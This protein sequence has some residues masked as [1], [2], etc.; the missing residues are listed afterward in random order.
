MP[1][2]RISLLFFL[3]TIS[4]WGP[5][6][7]SQK[8]EDSKD[9]RGILREIQISDQE[10]LTEDQREMKTLK[11]ELLISKSEKKAIESLNSLLKKKRGTL[12][13]PD[14][15]YR[16]A[17]LHMRRSKSGRFFDLNQDKTTNQWKSFPVPNEKGADS[18][19]ASIEIYNKIEKNFPNYKDLDS[20]LFNNAFA[21]QQI[22]LNRVAEVL[23]KKL[24]EKFSKSPLRA[25]GLLALAELL[26]EQ[27]RFK[28]A[29]TYFEK[30]KEFPDSRVYNYGL[31]KKAWTHYNMK[32]SDQGVAV[33]LEVLRLNPPNTTDAKGYNLRKESL[34]DLAV[35]V[36]DTKGPELLYSFFK[37]IETEEE[38]GQTILELAKLY[39]GH[40]RFK[41][42]PT[43]V[44]EYNDNHKLSPF[45]VKTKLILVNAYEST[46][47]REQVLETLKSISDLCQVGSAWYKAQTP[48]IFSESCKEDFKEVSLELSKKWW[49]IWLKNKLH[50]EFS[51]LTER[52]L[53][54]ILANDDPN[55]PDVKT[56]F[57]LAELLFQQEKYK[58]SSEEYEKVSLATQDTALA[59]DASYGALYSYEKFLNS[60]KSKSDPR[61]RKLVVHYKDNFPKGDHHWP[62]LMKWA[63]ILY[64]EGN[65]DESQKTLDLIKNN[66]GRKD[67]ITQSQDLHLDI[68][69]LKKDFKSL[70][71]KA[72]EFTSTELSAERK[73]H[74]QKISSEAHFSEVQEIAKSGQ[75]LK[76]AE[77]L[78]K[79]FREHP[80]SALGTEALWQSMS[81]Y[82]SLGRL[83]EASDLTLE[84]VA[85]HPKDKRNLDALKEAANA[86]VD[87]GNFR[88]ALQVLHKIQQ[89]EPTKQEDFTLK[90]AHYL[91]L[92]GDKE[93]ARKLYSQLE[94]SSNTVADKK[95]YRDLLFHT[96]SLQEKN[97]DNYRKFKK[98]QA[99]QGVEPF[100]S[101]AL[102]S[103][104][105]VLLRSG[106]ATEAFELARKI[107]ARDTEEEV[108]AQARSIQA[109]IL[110]EEFLRQSVQSSKEDRIAIVIGLKAEKMEKA[111]SSYL[112][113]LKQTKTSELQRTALE[114]IDRIY[115]NY[116]QSMGGF[117]AP[118]SV[119]ATDAQA[120]EIEIAKTLPPIRERRDQNRKDLL[121]LQ[122]Q[123]RGPTNEWYDSSP[124]NSIEPSVQWPTELLPPVFHPLTWSKDGPWRSVILTETQQ[125]KSCKDFQ[126][127]REAE[128]S[129]QNA[130]NSTKD[131]EAFNKIL[132][133]ASACSSGPDKAQLP[134][135][136]LNLLN[137]PRTKAL[138]Y[139]YLSLVSESKGLWDKAL[140][141]IEKAKLEIENTK[142]PSYLN[143]PQ[144]TL[145]T[146]VFSYQHLR[147]RLR[148]QG[149]SQ[150]FSDAKNMDSLLNIKW[151][152]PEFLLT[153]AWVQY[154]KSQYSSMIKKL[155]A[156][157]ADMIYNENMWLGYSEALAQ[158]GQVD[159][160]LQVLSKAKAQ[161][162][163]TALLQEARIHETIKPNVRLAEMLYREALTHTSQS[164]AKVWLEK[165]LEH[166]EKL[167][168]ANEPSG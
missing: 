97:S 59:H 38:L 168:G 125:K 165:K 162:L 119:A 4:L 115:E 91:W 50:K 60:Q 8:T 72:K 109:R 105:S 133:L 15:W 157:P 129:H 101:E 139:Y 149:W 121:A 83:R 7:Y 123:T 66:S 9:K 14:L 40:S 152:K 150:V 26:Y 54:H 79:F 37:K 95:K 16:L 11:A 87:L 53:R 23:Y 81:L 41:E 153:S 42:I 5:A 118:A 22:K 92:E 96:F 51:S 147:Q 10:N 166:L 98:T 29:L 151:D 57:A 103:Q 85:L 68:L 127:A 142:S 130:E 156:V 82:Y 75:G 93:S 159:R 20:V 120:I 134:N 24:E 61:Q 76:A 140:W 47:A 27:Q 74:L 62:I 128:S 154:N 49:E 155:S 12:E 122:K 143:I 58:E 141:A 56:R 104:A 86:K 160:A 67:L 21:H 99:D 28:E 52:A 161:N 13:E 32:D 114:G 90:T 44:N 43:F 18:I 2:P 163:V 39:D 1:A 77:A 148:S 84:F 113:L 137:D 89:L 17:E 78:L 48:E 116:L 3:L 33:L 136:S 144:V 167:N 106:R 138:G 145:A 64:D 110:E 73:S 126:D 46:K 158:T 124:E 69:N 135:L 111:L 36:G 35:F 102:L 25:D 30:L 100:A 31:Y 108:K 132:D 45:L 88:E 112:S 34:R 65:Y 107:M 63:L 146:Q 131:R 71:E 70:K 117:R 6:S 80:E 94:K 19:R 55:D 164:E